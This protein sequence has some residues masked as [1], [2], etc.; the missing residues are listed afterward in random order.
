[1][2]QTEKGTTMR[3]FPILTCACFLLLAACTGSSSNGTLD[4]EASATDSQTVQ[5]EKI[6]IPKGATASRVLSLLGPADSTDMADNGREMWRYTHKRAEYVYVSNSGAVQ[7]LV[8][9]NYNPSPNP[10][11]PG[12]TMLLTIV[13]DAAKKVADFNFALMAF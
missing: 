3:I 2:L 11:D 12:Q 6:I 1:M 5:Q 10:G 8:I 7:T 9:G 4:P 13:F